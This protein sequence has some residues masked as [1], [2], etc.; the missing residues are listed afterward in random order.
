MKRLIVGLLMTAAVLVVLMLLM[1][2]QIAERV[3]AD[4]IHKVVNK[5]QVEI[6][7]VSSGKLNRYRR[8]QSG[9]LEKKSHLKN[10]Y[11]AAGSSSARQRVLQEGN[12]VLYSY[13]V[14]SL[15]PFWYGTRWDY[16]GTSQVPGSGYIACGYFV[17]TSLR[18][19][20]F[21]LPRVKMAQQASEVAIRSLVGIHKL[22]RFSNVP[23]KRFMSTVD[24]SGDGLYVVGLDNHIGFLYKCG[25]ARHF[26]HSSYDYPG[27][28]QKENVWRSPML[29]SSKYRVYG[30]LT[31]DETLTRKWL[32]NEAI[33]ISYTM[34]HLDLY[35]V[36]F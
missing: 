22:K 3:G 6:K 9:L 18:D 34:H 8:I 33:Q 30:K 28:V 25:T 26:I 27:G 5:S 21:N 11:L 14:D 29:T 10:R 36:F 2:P 20:G 7:T 4:L 19:A 32:L 12:V 16:N 31:G 35:H 13:L 1:N 15:V 23:M 24:A 17:S